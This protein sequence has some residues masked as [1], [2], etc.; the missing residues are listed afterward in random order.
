[1]S[2]EPWI[3]DVNEGPRG[4][5]CYADKPGDPECRN[6]ATVHIL[7]E[8]AIHG[9]VTLPTCDRH[10]STA[11]AAGPV[12]GEHPYGSACQGAAVWW[13]FDGCVPVSDSGAAS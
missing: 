13:R 5:C 11:R 2:N 12:L 1:M 8:S 3:G 10:A 7:S 9:Q 6:P 4:G